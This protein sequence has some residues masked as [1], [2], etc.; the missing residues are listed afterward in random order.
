MHSCN[1]S[2]EGTLLTLVPISHMAAKVTVVIIG[3]MLKLITKVTM[4]ANV[5]I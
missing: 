3:T 2:N 4:V 1:D 5:T